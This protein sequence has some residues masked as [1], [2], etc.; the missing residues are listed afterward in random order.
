MTNNNNNNQQQTPGAKLSQKQKTPLLIKKSPSNSRPSPPTV[1]SWPS[2]IQETKSNAAPVFCFKHVPLS[3]F[4]N[5]I[6]SSVVL[7]VPNRPMPCA[8]NQEVNS[9]D[10]E[11]IFYWFACVLQYAGYWAKMRYFG[12]END[13][14]QD[15]WIHM[16]DLNVHEVG[17]SAETGHKIVPPDQIADQRDNWK[18]YLLNKIVGG[19]TLPSNFHKR[20]KKNFKFYHNSLKASFFLL[21]V[22]IINYY[23]NSMLYSVEII[24]SS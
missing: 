2:Y 7:E 1:F 5:Q 17:W 20:V 12:Y 15:F 23:G 13:S 24:E 21:T 6:T 22:S 16:C 10:G 9:S 11:E 3:N 8:L 14:S 18:N 19:K 4:W